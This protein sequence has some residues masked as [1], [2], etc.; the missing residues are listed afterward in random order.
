MF[1]LRLFCLWLFCLWLFSLW[2]FCLLLFSLCLVCKTTTNKTTSKTTN[3]ISTA[4]S[5]V[6]KS[7]YYK[8]FIIQLFQFF[9]NKCLL[10]RQICIFEHANYKSLGKYHLHIVYYRLLH[11]VPQSVKSIF[12]K[13]FLI[14][15]FKDYIVWETVVRSCQICF[16]ITLFRKQS[17]KYSFLASIN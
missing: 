14:C 16:A 10:F 17:C 1:C 8:F 12:S 15:V 6:V 7:E 4:T 11:V 9:R 3:T 2:L 5:W 13:W